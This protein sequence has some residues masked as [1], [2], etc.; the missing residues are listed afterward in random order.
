MLENYSGQFDPVCL[1]RVKNIFDDF[2]RIPFTLIVS[3]QY[4]TSLVDSVNIII[5]DVYN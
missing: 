3:R 4:L 1:W 5:R 2:S